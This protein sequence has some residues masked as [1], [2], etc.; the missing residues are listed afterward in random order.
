MAIKGESSGDR[1]PETG[2]AESNPGKGDA[3]APETLKTP[4]EESKQEVDAQKKEP[5]GDGEEEEQEEEELP[6]RDH[7]TWDNHWVF[8]FSLMSFT[9][10]VH[11]IWTFPY[12]MYS[13]GGIAFL[14]PYIAVT[15]VVALPLQFLEL[16]IGQYS[17]YGPRGIWHCLPIASGV[18]TAFKCLCTC[19]SI[20]A[21]CIL[22]LALCFI[23]SCF[24]NPLPWSHCGNEWN[25]A[26][27]VPL[28]TREDPRMWM[29]ETA[30]AK[31]AASLEAES[32]VDGAAIV[33][34]INGEG[35]LLNFTDIPEDLSEDLSDFK[36]KTHILS[37]MAFRY[38]DA[39]GNVGLEGEFCMIE[40][41]LCKEDA[42]KFCEP[43]TPDNVTCLCSGWSQ[44][45]QCIT[46]QSLVNVTVASPVEEF[47]TRFLMRLTFFYGE[48]E[49]PRWH[50]AICFLLS[51]HVV[52]LIIFKGIRTSPKFTIFRTTFPY[53]LMALI[54]ILCLSR[55]GAFSGI[56]ELLA[57]DIAKAFDPRTWYTA[58]MY[59]FISYSISQGGLIMIG[60][61]NKWNTD[62][63]T[64]SYFAIGVNALF[65]FLSA[66]AAFGAMGTLA[67]DLQ[68]PVEYFATRGPDV[69]FVVYAELLAKLP[70]AN[71]WCLLL[72]IMVFMMALNVELILVTALIEHYQQTKIHFLYCVSM[73]VLILTCFYLMGFAMIT[74]F[75]GSGIR[76]IIILV[77]MSIDLVPYLPSVNITFLHTFFLMTCYTFRYLHT[78][79]KAMVFAM[80][81]PRLPLAKD[82][83]WLWRQTMLTVTYGGSV[84][85]LLL[86]FF[87]LTGIFAYQP[88]RR[89]LSTFSLYYIVPYWLDELGWMFFIIGVFLLP[90]L[91][92]VKAF[93]GVVGTT[94]Q[95]IRQ[96][97][98]PTK[99]WAATDEVMDAEI[100]HE[101]GIP[102]RVKPEPVRER[103]PWEEPDV[104][105]D[106]E[107]NLLVTLI[108]GFIKSTPC[109]ILW[110][111]WKDGKKMTTTATTTT[112][113]R[114]PNGEAHGG[115]GWERIP[116]EDAM[117]E[118][119]EEE[120][121][122][123][124][125]NA[126]SGRGSIHDDTESSNLTAQPHH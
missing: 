64:A 15:L 79:V 28:M 2:S 91:G 57:P 50:L 106:N 105:A 93:V 84:T 96:I 104:E 45:A 29:N 54:L 115:D 20:H 80:R 77:V 40:P 120:E 6:P 74:D 70:G 76:L 94:N 42:I 43:E 36:N 11:S 75:V 44:P 97:V 18:G 110:R 39:A 117:T 102:I 121:E 67:H 49:T 71:F 33:S 68:V 85:T 24:K 4:I 5:K 112:T 92:A 31:L 88:S 52:A 30:V 61:Y 55:P 116:T 59:V 109:Y 69:A 22:A 58:V 53:C 103:K 63:I 37:H 56:G 7:V 47:W 66:F 78:D 3:P 23:L 12:L 72:Y 124:G 86:L 100:R 14:I 95:R 122:K 13:N 98:Y 26:A 35:L 21:N 119:E 90:I 34:G 101:L 27:C 41:F 48:G 99:A 16:F 111:N 114:A 17:G 25:T 65:S 123:E 60:S 108:L 126:Q 82:I 32:S 1:D 107:P 89:A 8:V 83:R 118:G 81:K 19:F 51:W 125:E 10:N 87:S 62:F 73:L 9:I 46:R 38:E 113:M